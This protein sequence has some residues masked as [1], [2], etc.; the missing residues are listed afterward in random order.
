MKVES[1][2]TPASPTDVVEVPE[3]Y[4]TVAEAARC[5]Q[6]STSTIYRMDRANGPVTFLIRGRRVFVHAAS[7]GSYIEQRR[8]GSEGPSSR[9]PKAPNVLATTN[10]ATSGV[11]HVQPAIV[12]SGRGQ[13]DLIWTGRV[14]R[15]AF[16]VY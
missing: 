16:F 6:R 10:G 15:P 11:H 1:S 3:G 13:R 7:L 9:D 12:S 2:C 5:L 8:N 14:P 4:I